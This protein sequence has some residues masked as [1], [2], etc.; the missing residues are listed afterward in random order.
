MDN[1]ATP[2]EQRSA[3]WFEQR[4]GRVTGSVVGAIL[5][6]SPYMTRADVMRQMVRASLGAEREFTGNV[7][8]EYGT[9]N[10]AGALIDF[11]METGLQ[12]KPAHFIAI[13]DWLGASPDGWTS[14]GGL[15][16]VKCPYG[17]RKEE[18]PV[19][20]TPDEQPHYLA[21][22]QVQ[23]HVARAP[24]CHFWQWATGG[25]RHDV[26]ARDDAWLNATLPILRQFHAEYLD[27]LANSP[28]EHIAPKRVEID[29]PEARKM[30]AEW[31]ELNDQLDRAA[32][33]KKDLLNDMIALAGEKN[34]LLSGR[35]LTLTQRA[36]AISYAK[37]IK[38]LAPDADLEKWRG[39]PSSFWQVR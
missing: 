3:A 13:D 17:K 31:D 23:M 21:Q 15:V 2:P 6:M 16:E 30:V 39:K 22:M 19:F 14:D 28:D 9:F 29:T 35:K 36:G 24:H 18:S 32:E 12:C 5:G 8:T 20:K 27:E 26:I 7:A 33:R 37:A 34:A 25:T 10:E 11:Q 38:V 1:T 4:K